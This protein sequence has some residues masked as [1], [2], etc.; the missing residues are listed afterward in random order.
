MRADL[1]VEPGGL[2]H[3]LP[4]PDERRAEPE[5]VERLGPKVDGEL[6]HVLQRRDDQ[7]S[8]RAAAASRAPRRPIPRAPRPRARAGSR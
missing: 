4:E 6:P 3:R 2:A 7:L 1:H 5:V 8:R